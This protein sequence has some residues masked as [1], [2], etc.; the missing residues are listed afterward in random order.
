MLRYHF[1]PCNTCSSY[2][3]IVMLIIWRCLDNSWINALD[4]PYHQLA[5]VAAANAN[6]VWPLAH[7]KGSSRIPLFSRVCVLGC[8]C[9]CIFVYFLVV[10]LWAYSCSCPLTSSLRVFS[11]ALHVTGGTTSHAVIVIGRVVVQMWLSICSLLASSS[12]TSQ[13]TRGVQCSY[14]FGVIESSK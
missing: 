3:Y 13:P 1:R 11:W 12:S 8:W 10:P 6:S 14:W 7:F 5:F 4:L 9:T 2:T